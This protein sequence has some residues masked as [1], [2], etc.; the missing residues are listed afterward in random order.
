LKQKEKKRAVG[1]S[2]DSDNSAE[3]TNVY[4][5]N[6]SER[7]IYY[8]RINIKETKKS[9][10]QKIIKKGGIEKSN[11]ILFVRIR[12]DKYEDTYF[13]IFN[14]STDDNTLI[15]DNIYFRNHWKDGI[16]VCALKKD[17]PFELTVLIKE[18]DK[19]GWDRDEIEMKVVCGETVGS[20]KTRILQEYHGK[21]TKWRVSFSFSIDDEMFLGVLFL[22]RVFDL[23][24]EN[25]TKAITISVRLVN[26]PEEERKRLGLKEGDT[27]NRQALPKDDIYVFERA[28]CVKYRIEKENIN[29]FFKSQSF[30][31]FFWKIH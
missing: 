28:F 15:Y 10:I 21:V 13:T 14:L 27:V 12:I 19:E 31:F 7:D 8:I 29:F 2:S 3:E 4:V 16:V 6:E 5:I 11:L 23:F 18:K 20:L 17:H 1:L 30:S 26:F 9:M 22:E 25:F 24:L